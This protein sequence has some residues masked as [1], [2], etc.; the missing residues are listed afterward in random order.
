MVEPASR[1]PHFPPG[2]GPGATPG[3][4]PRDCVR[5]CLCPAPVPLFPHGRRVRLETCIPTGRG[6]AWRP[7]WRGQGGWVARAECKGCRPCAVRCAGL[8]RA[9]SP[10]CP[11]PS[12]PGAQRAGRSPECPPAPRSIRA[13]IQG[14][15]PGGGGGGDAREQMHYTPD[16]PAPPQPKVRRRIDPSLPLHSLI[17]KKITIAVQSLIVKLFSQSPWRKL[18]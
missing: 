6:G 16:G 4:A 14:A 13:A 10:A 18:S 17:E 2:A 3:A 1:R 15:R 5:V 11:E 8:C 7:G 9:R 12:V